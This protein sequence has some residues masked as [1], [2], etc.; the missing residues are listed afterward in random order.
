MIAKINAYVQHCAGQPED[1]AEAEP[2]LL[3]QLPS[4]VYEVTFQSRDI[5]CE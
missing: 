3:I 2:I 5:I 1:D 4:N